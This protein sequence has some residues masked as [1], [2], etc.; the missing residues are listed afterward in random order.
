MF[1]TTADVPVSIFDPQMLKDDERRQDL[2]EECVVLESQSTGHW[3]LRNTSP[4][5][6]EDVSH[7]A[8]GYVDWLSNR[9]LGPQ[10]WLIHR[11]WPCTSE[12]SGASG[13]CQRAQGCQVM[14]CSQATS[15]R[16]LEIAVNPVF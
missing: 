12:R 4:V 6:T 14:R 2:Q 11:W 10:A 1:S 9:H 15:D 13:T 3:K 7:G 8:I 5:L 16:T